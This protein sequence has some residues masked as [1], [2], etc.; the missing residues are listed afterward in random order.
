MRLNKTC[1]QIV[2]IDD[3]TNPTISCI[4]NQIVQLPEGVT[5]YTVSGTEF[6]PT[7]SNDNCDGFNIA[8]NINNL[9]TLN[10]VEFPLGSTTVVWTIT[11]IANNETQCSFDVQVD[12]FV[13]IEALQQK[14]IS[15][16]PNPANEKLNLESSN[17]IQELIISDINGK[18]IIKKTEI[19]QN[20]TIDL[21]G[22][23][24]GIYIISIQTEK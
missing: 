14:G 23:D 10:G 19:Q 18:Q 20:E 24:S 15:I 6:D 1:N 5:V 3:I 22:F 13:G 21:S 4:N 7:A 2:I 17:N 16:Y 8:N 9:S 12:V 11:D